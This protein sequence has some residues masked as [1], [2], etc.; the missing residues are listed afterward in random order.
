MLLINA[1]NEICLKKIFL[2]GF[3]KGDKKIKLSRK[4]KHHKKRLKKNARRDF[5]GLLISYNF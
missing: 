1:I 3:L 4:Q 2:N 5:F